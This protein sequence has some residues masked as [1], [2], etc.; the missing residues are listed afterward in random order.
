MI[1]LHINNFIDIE[2]AY[3]MGAKIIQI[4]SPQESMIPIIK[5]ELSK[6]NIEI[7]IHSSYEINIAYNWNKKSI[8]IRKLILE[9]EKANKL[10]AIGLVIHMGK[11]LKLDKNIAYNNM[12]NSLLYVFKKT[13]NLKPLIFLETPS[14]QGSELG[15]NLGEMSYFFNKLIRTSKDVEKKFKICIDTCHVF[16]SGINFNDLEITKKYFKDFG[17]YIG[18]KYL[19]LIHLNNSKNDYGTKIDRHDNLKDGKINLKN[20]LYIKNFAVKHN[21]SVILETPY[22]KIFNDLKILISH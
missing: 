18:L 2:K 22:N 17:D 8:H 13:K 3:K 11:K 6:V 1:G 7:V 15:F 21:I 16:A 20:L 14:G 12:L 9:M 4:M 19:G 5:H 10:N